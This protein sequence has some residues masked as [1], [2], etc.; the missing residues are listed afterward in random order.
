MMKI[1]KTLFTILLSGF[2]MWVIAGLWHNLV[3]PLI[4]AEHDAHHEGIF[5]MLLAYFILAALMTYFYSHFSRKN[6]KFAGLEIGVIIGILW[7]FPHGLALAGAHDTSIIYEIKNTLWHCFE[8]GIG[9]GLI[10]LLYKWT[11]KTKQSAVHN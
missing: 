6:S 7:V 2:A 11:F 8:Q 3:L 9:G 4:S 5:I 10:A 1:L